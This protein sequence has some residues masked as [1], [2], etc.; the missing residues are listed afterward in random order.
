[1]WAT[2]VMPPP[3]GVV[4]A[5]GV[6]EMMSLSIRNTGPVNGLVKFEKGL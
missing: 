6:I 4:D 1:M 2:R 5:A 3:R